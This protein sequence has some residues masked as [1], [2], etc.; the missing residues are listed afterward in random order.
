MQSEHHLPPVDR[1][2]SPEQP[3]AYPKISALHAATISLPDRIRRG[4]Q[5]TRAHSLPLLQRF[6]VV[7]IGAII[8]ALGYSL[9]QLPFNL[10]GGGLSGVGIIVNHFT[11]WPVGTL[12]FLLNIP[13]L[14]IGFS[15]LGRWKFLISTLLAVWVFAVATDLFVHYLPMLL[16]PYPLTNDM[17]LSA[18]Y[19]GLISGIGTGI[20]YTMGGTLGS[21]GILARI[22]QQKTGFPLSQAYLYADGSIILVSGIVFGWE[23]ALHA[24]LMMFLNGLASDFTLEG[25]STVRTI[26][27]V[28]QH[29]AQLTCAILETTHLG[30]S[31]WSINDG[32][33]GRNYAMII[34]TVHRPHVREVKRVVATT[35]PEAF[36]VIGNS[37]QALGRGFAPLR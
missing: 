33:T 14:I 8:A 23:I 13:L 6:L 19:A 26:T 21:T 11:G 4:F 30:V 29:P 12:Y 20:I 10:A 16:S 34:C 32:Y 15:S 31:S 17:L 36:V 3:D 2:F 24:L 22:I 5:T 1:P 35:D 37:H 7:C 28:T 18:M 9:F 25:P 27:I